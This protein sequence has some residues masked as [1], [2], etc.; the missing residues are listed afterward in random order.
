MR[1][2]SPREE[3]MKRRLFMRTGVIGPLAVAG[4]P[5]FAQIPSGD[6]KTYMLVS[7]TW[8]GGWFM[9]PLADEL[10]V[11]GHRVFAP[12]N[13]G[14]GERKHLLSQNITLDTF[15]IDVMNV[16]EAEELR[17]VILVGHSSAG[18]PI[19]GV[20]DRMPDRIRHLVYLD[21]VLAQ[22]GQNFLDSWPPDMAETRRK[23]VTEINGVRVLVPPSAG[24]GT[25]ENPVVAWFYRRLTPQPFA[26][27]ETPL[28]LGHPVGNGLPCTYVAFT[29]SPN[30]AL[31]PSRTWVRSQKDWHWAELPQNH[32]A[33]AFAPKEVAQ[34][35]AGIS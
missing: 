30:P 4:E 31:E 15:I 33:P 34:I 27:F 11:K 28:V 26:T 6:G 3:K 32:P 1:T 35:L 19:T 18:L 17:D 23:A 2:R 8:C 25:P 24:P 29:K 20:A 16:I 21:G 7:G 12:T 10:R 14:L 13:T 9:R 5:V 22:S